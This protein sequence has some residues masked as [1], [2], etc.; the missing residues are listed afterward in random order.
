MGKVR[1][2]QEKVKALDKMTAKELREMA[3]AV[4]GIVGVHAMNKNE[5]VAVIQEAKGIVP[6]RG[7]KAD[8]DIRAIKGKMGELREK[9]LAALEAG[10]RKVADS[11]KRRISTLKKKTR[12]VA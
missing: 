12:R 7:K 11:F 8:V 10:N 5:L 1:E 6:E 9:R 4:G 2:K 3:L